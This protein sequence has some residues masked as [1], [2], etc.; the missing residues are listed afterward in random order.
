MPLGLTRRL[1]C[2]H[3][4]GTEIWSAPNTYRRSCSPRR[5]TTSVPTYRLI[6][7][8]RSKPQLQWQV[9][10]GQTADQTQEHSWF[11]K[12]RTRMHSQSNHEG[13]ALW[14]Q[15]V[16]G[17][18]TVDWRSSR[19]RRCPPERPRAHVDPVRPRTCAPGPGRISFHRRA[20]GA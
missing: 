4:E 19:R 5:R 3:R 2:V 11:S 10:R 12:S 9:S 14:W 17:H 15:G 18:G 6:Q 1:T 7:T 8:R 13:L 16:P 20:L